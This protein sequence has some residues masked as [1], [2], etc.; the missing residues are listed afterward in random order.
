MRRFNKNNKIKMSRYEY[1]ER[2][3][4]DSKIKAVKIKTIL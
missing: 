2:I 1:T 4:N 3:N